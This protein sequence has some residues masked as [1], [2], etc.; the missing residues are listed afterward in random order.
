MSVRL[1]L[2]LVVALVVA[3]AVVLGVS[4]AYYATARELHSQVDSF[5]ASR[6]QRVT[7]GPPGRGLPRPGRQGPDRGGAG[8]LADL[9]AVVQF[10]APD[11]TPTPASQ[12]QPALPVADTDLE[13]VGTPGRRFRDVEVAGVEYRILTESIPGGG[14]VQIAR[15]LDETDAVLASLRTVLVLVACAGTTVAALVAWAVARRLTRPI[16]QL[17]AAAE[18]VARTQDLSA[19]IPVTR[20]DEVGRLARSFNTMLAA[21]AASREQ[22][23]RLVTDASHELR[24]PL[25]V[26]RTNIELLQRSGGLGAEETAKLLE[27]TH[28]ELEELTEVVAELV[29]LA[30]DVADA[31]PVEEVDLGALAYDV[32][33]RF[34]RRSGRAVEVQVDAA[35]SCTICGRPSMLDRALGNLVDNALKFSAPESGVC[36]SVAGPV[37]EVADRG[38]GIDAADGERVFGRFYRADAARSAPGSGLGLAIVRRI[39]DVHGGTASVHPRPGG[40]TIARLDLGTRTDAG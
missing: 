29:D 22:Q 27:D 8:P 2:T 17:S 18:H 10:I 16:G 14:A 32:A 1:R 30:S 4:A 40:G 35:V 25:T 12:D 31:E 26:V 3:A 7:Q 21:L 36:V 5:L 37:V 33:A 39:A 6:A 20:N 24:T 38:P 11:G 19:E 13:V 9:D 28:L 15:S 34:A 23:R